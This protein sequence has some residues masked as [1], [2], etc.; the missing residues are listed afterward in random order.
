MYLQIGQNVTIDFDKATHFCLVNENRIDFYFGEYSV[1]GH[2]DNKDADAI[3]KKLLA[4]KD[5]KTISDI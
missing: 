3:Y 5:A 2:F 4:L 1:P